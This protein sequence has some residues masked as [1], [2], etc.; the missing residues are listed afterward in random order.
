MWIP[1]IIAAGIMVYGIWSLFGIDRERWDSQGRK[2]SNW[3]ILMLAFG[4]LAVLLFFG[5][6]RPQ[7]L[8]PE[9]YEVIDG[10]AAVDR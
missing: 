2:R 10:V 7:L 9:R 3:V 8:Y 5:T 6:V 4:P 1:L